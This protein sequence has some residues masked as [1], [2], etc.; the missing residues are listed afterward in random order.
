MFD[1]ITFDAGI[2]GG[3][4]CI[5]GMRIPVSVIAGRIAH[6]A[7]RE[8]ILENY[9]DLEGRGI[10]GAIEHAAWL[11]EEEIHASEDWVAPFLR[12]MC[13]RYIHILTISLAL[14]LLPGCLGTQSPIELSP[15]LHRPPLEL[16]RQQ[17]AYA[18]GIY[19]FFED[20]CFSCHDT[21]HQES[22][23]DLE[24][25][26][27]ASS[28]GENETTWERVL[29]M[30]RSGQMPPEKEFPPSAVER[31]E[32]AGFIEKE[33][34]A[35]IRAMQPDPGR[36]TARRLNRQEYDNTVRD[37]L[38]IDSNPSRA[39]PV[40]DSGYGFDNNGDVLSLSPLLMEKYLSAAE[41]LVEAATARELDSPDDGAAADRYLF[42]CGHGRGE[43]VKGC[44]DT[45][46]RR[47][48]SRAYR[49]P[50][51]KA[52][53][54]GL[55]RLAALVERQGDSFEEGIELAIGAVLVSP[56][57]LFRIERGRDR[58]DPNALQYVNDFELASRLS[59]FL[60]STMPDEELF[61]LARAEE[62]RNPETLSAQVERMI[63]DERSEAFVSN[64]AGQWLELRNLGLVRRRREQFPDFDRQL[65]RAM[66]TE[67]Y[68]FFGAILRENRSIL[69][70]L[71]SNFTFA[72]ERLAEHYGWPGVEGEDHR[73]I[74]L[75]GEQRGGVL[76]QASVLTLTSYPTRTS[77]VLRGA[78]VLENIL[79]TVPPPPPEEVPPLEDDPRKIEGTL[80]EQLE[81]HRSGALCASCHSRFDPLGFGLEN[82]DATG[83]WRTEERGFP[84]DSSGV[85]PT[86]ES[87]EGSAE[88]RRI[89]VTHPEKFVRTL[90]EKV[91]TYAL[92]RG[93]E[94]FDRPVVAAIEERVAEDGYRFQTLIREIV[95]SV[96]FRMR[97]GEG[98]SKA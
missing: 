56:N 87:F 30:L 53:V 57:F 70:F 48:A 71:D 78:W 47:F 84:V 81:A 77:P 18:S 1:R 29:A 76:T 6:G 14:I 32:V 97:R 33:L 98:E 22:G 85:L 42:V 27:L 62:L 90:T 13:I 8:E 4:A 15:A 82:Y 52:D 21:K 36:V 95:L 46:L 25:A 86:G 94:V 43:H 63:A 50:V 40:D 66:A 55:K 49:R 38:G 60:W 79:G 31:E 65:R 96:P 20:Y 80:R 16:A 24:A 58:A 12:G 54:R 7:A 3:R 11:A 93:V 28:I 5:R 74:T 75:F 45:I 26:T 73:R 17:E 61:A 2:M 19:P 34:D 41:D 64:F 91:L 23:I 68:L 83:A 69:N 67:S 44:A 88:L 39:F 51:A 72:N 37:L 92:G 9:P 35:A 89:L 10:Q 59:Y